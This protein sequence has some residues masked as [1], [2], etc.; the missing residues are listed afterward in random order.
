M[1][2]E[3]IFRELETTERGLSHAEADVRRDRFGPNALP[4]GKREGI[5]TI[6]FRQFLS[7]LI[8][9]LLFASV[10][11]FARGDRVDGYIILFIL[12]F[13]AVV[14]AIQEGRAKNTVDA[15]RR[16]TKGTATVLRDGKE[17]ILPDEEIVPGDVIFLYEGEKIP[18]D[19]RVIAARNLRV[20]Q[21]ALT[22]E[23]APTHKQSETLPRDGVP[24]P[25][26]SNMIFRGTLV[27]GGSGEAVVVATGSRTMLG[28]LSERISAVDTE[29]PLARQVRLLARAVAIIVP[30][31]C[32]LIFALGI[33]LGKPIEEMLSTVVSLAVSVIPE[34]LPI[35]LTL[36]LA[37]GMWRMSEHRVL[38]KRLQAVEAL[39]GVS[40]IAV[41][42][43]G[44]IT[45]NKLIV[46]KV[47]VGGDT[48]DV[49]GTGY[50]PAGGIRRGE[51]PVD[52]AN[53]PEILILGKIASLSASAKLVFSEEEREWRIGGDPT[54][55]AILV[56]GKKAGFRKEKLESE[57][58]AVAELPFDYKTKRHITLYGISGDAFLSVTGAPE[59]VLERSSYFWKGGRAMPLTPGKRKEIEYEYSQLSRSGLRVVAAAY[60]E[61]RRD[62]LRVEEAD[63]LIF[64]GFFA[65]KDALRSGVRG[66]VETV[67]NAGVRVV[68]ITGDNRETA[69]AIAREAGIFRMRDDVIT[70][71]EVERMSEEELASRIDRVSV[72]ARVTP[73]HKLR[74][75]EAY[76]SRGEVVAMTG[77]GVND[78]PPLVAADVGVSMGRIG[79]EVA[80]ESSD[81]VLLDDRFE[82]IVDAME[83]GRSIFRTIRNVVIFLFST[84]LAELA[85]ITGALLLGLPLPL[86]AVQILWLNLVADG[87]LD[88]SLAME[89]RER[90]LLGKRMS[91]LFR[92]SLLDRRALV[93]L[94][95][96]A[97]PM[98]IGTLWIF[99]QSI[100]DSIEKSWTI[101]L[102]T[103]V[104]FHWFNV[105][106]CRREDVSVF[107]M[108]PFSN[109]YLLVAFSVIVSLQLLAVY[110]PFLQSILH[111]AP[112]SLSE[113]GM[114]V[115]VASS[116]LVAEE[117]R[118]FLS[119]RF[120][121][122]KA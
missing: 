80:K 114:I 81:I 46:E 117:I 49:E 110:H 65:M 88:V 96:M 7:P 89:P 27:S 53:H 121:T 95:V 102:T 74:I 60:R 35:V 115:A 18:A 66:A 48:F 45:E 120:E 122:V 69:E 70:G 10:I 54:E 116:I 15:L 68:M 44:T 51:R 94:L 118:K 11:V 6:F 20:E 108:N 79:T 41:D 26:L 98:T 19:A 37:T 91:R 17:V 56:F 113:W 92:Y 36:V 1:P 67:R 25:D 34:G 12:L 38:V 86:L 100:G 52:P 58:P 72:F 2:A 59:A 84:N 5:F 82:N 57:M 4:E 83:E 85:T 39:G 42:K 105:W 33:S 93:R 73:E 28:S 71:G 62:A 64:V 119:R 29:I 24:F 63:D 99:S 8:F 14:G 61:D 47:W 101:A 30:V 16:F 50:D 112:L 9:I 104:V 106:S 75:V 13:N 31:L 87:F 43:T 107:R 103:L 90:G 22:G 32:A 40:V 21:A 78:A 97:V 111:T 76:R 55:A 77:D 3:K 109:R 23:S